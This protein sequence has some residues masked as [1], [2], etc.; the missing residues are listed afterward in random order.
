MR[1]WFVTAHSKLTTR[2]VGR[3]IERV[4]FGANSTSELEESSS[5]SLPSLVSLQT[6]SEELGRLVDPLDFLVP[7]GELL[8]P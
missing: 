3:D 8:E 7:A 1:R 2:T 5:V 6:S 4:S